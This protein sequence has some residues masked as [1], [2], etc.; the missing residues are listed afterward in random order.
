MLFLIPMMGDAKPLSFTQLLM[1]MILTVTP[2]A[3]SLFIVNQ[4]IEVQPVGSVSL[5]D[6]E[7][8]VNIRVSIQPAGGDAQHLKTFKQGRSL[9]KRTLP[10]IDPHLG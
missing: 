5:E 2:V 4:I 10:S 6:P 8:Q 9:Q 3:G 1:S 7:N